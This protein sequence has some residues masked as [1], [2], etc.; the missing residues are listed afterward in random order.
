MEVINV[1]VKLDVKNMK[2]ER[3]AQKTLL[4]ALLKCGNGNCTDTEGGFNC[5]CHEGWETIGNKTCSNQFKF[6]KL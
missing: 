2:M 1:N 3:I 4:N 5:I 6:G